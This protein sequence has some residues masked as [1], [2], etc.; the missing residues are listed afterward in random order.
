[1][2]VFLSRRTARILLVTLVGSDC[3]EQVSSVEGS[4][5]LRVW[6][7]FFNNPDFTDGAPIG[8]L[9]D[10]ERLSINWGNQVFSDI[11]PLK[12]LI[13]LRYLSLD[14]SPVTDLSAITGMTRL[15]QLNLNYIQATDVSAILN[16]RR[17][18]HLGLCQL[19]L[20]SPPDL[21][22]LTSLMGLSFCNY[23]FV[24][25]PLLVER[26]PDSISYLGL[27]NSRITSTTPLT[28]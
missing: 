28:S 12:R 27:Q 20:N 2:H 9:T 3:H 8:A 4:K 21:R 24:D 26:L 10:L 5:T 13:N 22:S 1:M 7:E 11:D 17:L 23:N 19:P 15:E 14:G 18:Q 16:L 6:K 25:L